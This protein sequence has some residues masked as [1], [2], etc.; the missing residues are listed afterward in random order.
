MLTYNCEQS[1]N[2]KKKTVALVAVVKN[3]GPYLI[4]W[5]S[6]HLMLGV[7]HVYL[8]D[9]GS[10]DDS[11]KAYEIMYKTGKLTVHRALKTGRRHRAQE[12]CYEEWRRQYGHLYTFVMPWDGD[13]FL[14]LREGTTLQSFLNAIPDDVG[15]IRIN[16]KVFGS[17]DQLCA[18]F[19]KF[20]IERFTRHS[21]PIYNEI[22]KLVLR[23]EAMGPID[24][25]LDRSRAIC[26]HCSD[27][28]PEYRTVGADLVTEVESQGNN[29]T[30]RI[31]NGFA[32]C[33]H[34]PLKSFEEF[35]TIKKAKNVVLSKDQLLEIGSSV[36]NEYYHHWN[37]NELVDES[38]LRHVPALRD[39]I[40]KVKSIVLHYGW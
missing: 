35:I 14:W 9:D 17:G 31:W 32:I 8:Y 12:D 6:Y 23:V 28:L 34:Y 38:M 22:T 15:Q 37:H 33:N 3:E 16:W 27:V 4:E 36:T 2:D 1:A 21:L 25:E 18:D 19:S 13:E 26:A 24:V 29:I 20:V 7:D 40:E 11:W 30:P 5:I 10:N 39:Y